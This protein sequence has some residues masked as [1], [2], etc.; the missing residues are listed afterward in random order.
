MTET[1]LINSL[2]KKSTPKPKPAEAPKER[3]AS[4]SA[5]WRRCPRCN[6]SNH[7]YKKVT[8]TNWCRSCGCEFTVDWEKERVKE[9]KPK[10]AK[11]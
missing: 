11:T 7:Y 10:G 8:D 4:G 5:H 6:T 3:I 2:S 1:K 9:V